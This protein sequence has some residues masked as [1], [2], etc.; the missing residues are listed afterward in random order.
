MGV[1]AHEIEIIISEP[2]YILYIRIQDHVRQRAWRAA[3]LFMH[4]VE[5]VQID[6][7]ITERMD[8]V[9]GLQSAHLSHHLR[10]QSIARDI[11]RDT[12]KTVTA[13][14]IELA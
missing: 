9:A 13:A 10:E 14:L 4:L 7:G 6:M 1:V 8:E 2:E 12:Q 3:Q 11:E 5:M